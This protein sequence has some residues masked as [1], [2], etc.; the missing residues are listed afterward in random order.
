MIHSGPDCSTRFSR[1]GVADTRGSALRKSDRGRFGI[2]LLG[3]SSYSSILHPRLSC[4]DLILFKACS[5]RLI[6]LADIQELRE[7][8]QSTLDQ[9]YLVAWSKKLGVQIPDS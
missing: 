2:I 9:T 3:L 4:E 5:G 7:R 8:N 1:K 6:D